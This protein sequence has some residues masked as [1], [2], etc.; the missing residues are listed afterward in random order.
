MYGESE[1]E[2]NDSDEKNE[3]FYNTVQNASALFCFLGIRRT[4]KDA[5][6]FLLLLKKKSFSLFQNKKLLWLHQYNLSGKLWWLKT[7]EKSQSLWLKIVF[8]WFPSSLLLYFLEGLLVVFGVWS[9]VLHIYFCCFT[10]FLF[11]IFMIH[12]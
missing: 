10:I 5:T 11:Y 3:A 12:F 4:V 6:P 7:L 1:I 2:S 8:S 9:F